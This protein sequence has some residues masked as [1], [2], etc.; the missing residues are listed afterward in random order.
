MR[1]I[2]GDLATLYDTIDKMRARQLQ[3]I[4]RQ[5]PEVMAQ[6][7]EL[8]R[9]ASSAILRQISARQIDRGYRELPKAVSTAVQDLIHRLEHFYRESPVTGWELSTEFGL[10]YEQRMIPF[11]RIGV[12]LPALPSALFMLLHIVVPARIAGVEEIVIASPMFDDVEANLVTAYACKQLGIKELYAGSDVEAV[13]AFTYGFSSTPGGEW[14][15]APVEKIFAPGGSRTQ[16]AKRAVYGLVGLD[17]FL[18]DPDL[19]ILVDE[20][21]DESVVC[22]GVERQFVMDPNSNVTVFCPSNRK[23][24]AII[25]SFVEITTQTAAMSDQLKTAAAQG[26]YLFVTK[27]QREALKVIDRL[28]PSLLYLYGRSP[29]E[30]R[31][32]LRHVSLVIESAEAFAENVESLLGPSFLGQVAGSARFSS[33]L[34][35]SDFVRST[36]WLTLNDTLERDRLTTA[37]RKLGSYL[38][39]PTAPKG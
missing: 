6:M 2:E 33:S 28:A 4:G 30:A 1:L 32:S 21:C 23:A 31:P 14:E 22:E 29:E 20:K 8:S 19:A 13:Y 16:A 12:Y 35:L 34:R 26:T 15:C 37:A 17:P 11:R 39:R 9:Q 18:G 7:A 10:S 38:S 36:D 5:V 27:D 24:S 3:D 25:N